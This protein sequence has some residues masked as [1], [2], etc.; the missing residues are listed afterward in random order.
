MAQKGKMIDLGEVMK[1]IIISS[2]ISD[3][4]KIITEIN[5]QEMMGNQGGSIQP[6]QPKQPIAPIRDKDIL[7][8]FQA[9]QQ[10][11]Q[12]GGVP[13]MPRGG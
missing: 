5:P 4:E 13:P 9:V 1:R 8:T 12:G 6:Q 11:A 10:M 7:K 2:G 3:Y